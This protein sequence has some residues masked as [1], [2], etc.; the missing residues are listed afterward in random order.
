MLFDTN[1]ISDWFRGVESLFTLVAKRPAYFFP[2]VAVGEYRHGLEKSSQRERLLPRFE[3]LL[4]TSV[5]LP[6]TAETARHYARLAT[7]QDRKGRPVPSNDLWIAALAVEHR[8]PI[9]S[10]D[11][12]FQSIDGIDVLTW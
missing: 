3:Q 4:A 2:A 1:A 11:A 9:L 5:T 8:L 12:H 7:Q 6:V 10:R